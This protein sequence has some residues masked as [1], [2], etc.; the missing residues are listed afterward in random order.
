MGEIRRL[1][2]AIPSN[3]DFSSLLQAE[4]RLSYPAFEQEVAAYLSKRYGP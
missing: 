3:P 2:K 1:L 4:I